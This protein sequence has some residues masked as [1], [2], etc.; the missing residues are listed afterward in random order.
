MILSPTGMLN[1]ASMYV[2]LL[3]V[4]VFL[5]MSTE[6]TRKFAKH[7]FVRFVMLF[8]AAYAI[9][10]DKLAALVATCLFFIFEVRNFILQTNENNESVQET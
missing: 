8:S 2:N 4:A 9:F 6:S 10:P 7:P 5:D 3:T 1:V